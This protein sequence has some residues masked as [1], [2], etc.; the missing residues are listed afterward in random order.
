LDKHINLR[1]AE[2]IHGYT[3]FD[4]LEWDIDERGKVK[5]KFKPKDV[6]VSFWHADPKYIQMK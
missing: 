4:P 2:H 1:D 3:E 6:A 5:I